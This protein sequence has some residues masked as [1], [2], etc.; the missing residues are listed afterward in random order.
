MIVIHALAVVALLPSFWS[1]PAITSLLVLYW[2]TSNL[3]TIAQ[4][5]VYQRL[6]S[7]G[8]LGG[9]ESS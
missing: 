4:Q 1:W 2:V 8:I 7:K 3:M 9:E 6:R 5:G